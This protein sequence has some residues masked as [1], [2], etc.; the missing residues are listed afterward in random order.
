MGGPSVT[1]TVSRL[2]C[3][4]FVGGGMMWLPGWPHG[5]R[6]AGS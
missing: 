4:W 2:D 1:P 3:V 5:A 6:T